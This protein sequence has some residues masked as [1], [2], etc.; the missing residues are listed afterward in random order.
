MEIAAGK[1][2]ARCLAIMRQVQK[3]Q[4][5]VVITKFGKPIAKLSPIKGQPPQPIFGFMKGT[6]TIKGDIVGP[7]GEKWDADEEAPG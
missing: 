2:K 5:E 6:V 3:F 1:F 7:T 4:Q